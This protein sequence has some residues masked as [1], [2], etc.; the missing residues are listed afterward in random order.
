MGTRTLCIVVGWGVR[1]FRSERKGDR[2]VLLVFFLLG[3]PAR[4]RHANWL[5][6]SS[7]RLPRY[8]SPQY[9]KDMGK[10]AKAAVISAPPGTR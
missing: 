3:D 2:T 9:C 1:K 5:E 10:E 8:E 6:V 7:R 4:A